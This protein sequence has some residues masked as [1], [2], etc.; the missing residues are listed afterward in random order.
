M[1]ASGLK[2]EGEGQFERR[3][4]K[5]ERLAARRTSSRG[6]MTPSASRAARLVS[7]NES[8]TSKQNPGWK[9]PT[10]HGARAKLATLAR[11]RSARD[12]GRA[13]EIVGRLAGEAGSSELFDFR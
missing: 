1:P 12:S 7:G 11:W 6:L 4:K 3:S 10:H 2:V 8:E 5:N 9:T 13:L